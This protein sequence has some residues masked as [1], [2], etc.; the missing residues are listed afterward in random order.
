LRYSDGVEIDEVLKPVSLFDIQKDKRKV[1]VG[2]QQV[3]R[4]PY[5]FLV[6]GVEPPPKVK[7][8]KKSKK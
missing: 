1:L 7:R 2:I 6:Q 4:D 3:N 5:V 8:K